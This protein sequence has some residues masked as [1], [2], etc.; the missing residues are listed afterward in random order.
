[1]FQ[2]YVRKERFVL[3]ATRDFGRTKVF[4]SIMHKLAWK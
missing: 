1:M 2:D 4:I 3:I